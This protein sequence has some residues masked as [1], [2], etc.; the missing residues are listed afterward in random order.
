MAQGNAGKGRPKGSLNRKTI[1]LTALA[2]DGES[3]AEL[4]LRISRDD[5]Q[6]LDVRLNAAR[7]VMPYIHPRPMPQ[8]RLVQVPLPDTST[9]RGIA[10][11]VGSVLAAASSGQI[12]PSEAKDLT[13]LLG[14][15]LKALEVTDLEDRIAKLEARNNK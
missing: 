9:A 7:T 14:A 1:E 11:A 3:P 13:D 12:A 2:S 15:R 5:S 4:C 8:P 10:E 6:Q